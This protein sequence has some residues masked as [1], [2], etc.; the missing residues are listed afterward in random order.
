MTII[1]WII[2]GALALYFSNAHDK[3]MNENF[4]NF[5]IRFDQLDAKIQ[6]LEFDN[7]TKDET[8]KDLY[9]MIDSL[10][11]RIYELEKPYRESFFDD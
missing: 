10:K 6:S 7:D 8:I 4:T 5:L 9:E 11:D 3:K 1:G 2:F